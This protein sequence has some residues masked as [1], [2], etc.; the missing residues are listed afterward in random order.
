[1]AESVLPST[2]IGSTARQALLLLYCM[3]GSMDIMRW[4][5]FVVRQQCM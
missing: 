1:M 3:P 5:M 4:F 2:A